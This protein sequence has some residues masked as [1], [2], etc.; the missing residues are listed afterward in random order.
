M[1]SAAETSDNLG[2]IRLSLPKSCVPHHPYGQTFTLN[3][4]SIGTVTL[5]TI[6]MF[7]IITLEINMYLQ[8][9]CAA[10]ALNLSY[11][12]KT[13]TCRSAFL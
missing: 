12:H 1:I 7:L 4:N 5:P 6:G 11:M 3:M 9:A 10:A 8:T 2:P 13:E